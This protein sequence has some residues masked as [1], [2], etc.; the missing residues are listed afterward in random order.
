MDK[1]QKFLAHA[2]QLERQAARRYEEL[3]AAMQTDGRDEL[4]TFFRRMAHYSRL[5]LAD[6]MKRGAFRDVPD[7]PEHEYEWPDGLPPETAE[8]AGA[9]AQM[10][11]ADALDLALACERRGHAYYAA[12]AATS[13]DPE[14]R[15]LASE[16]AEEEAGHMESLLK[17]VEKHAQ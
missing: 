6:A 9:D 15:L 17:L 7:L 14:V 11:I 1:V 16:F 13:S 4:R 5:H 3:A 10:G 12:I 2:I 8:W